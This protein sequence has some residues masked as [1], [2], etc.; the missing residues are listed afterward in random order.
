[1]YEIC[2]PTS[3]FLFWTSFYS[4]N[5]LWAALVYTLVFFLSAIG[6]QYDFLCFLFDRK[7]LVR[8]SVRWFVTRYGDNEIG[9][10]LVIYF[11]M[12]NVKLVIF[13]SKR[14]LAF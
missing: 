11:R 10:V 7:W 6:G 8:V 14:K 3:F 9:L 13:F 4:F 2:E 12:I 5:N 1:M